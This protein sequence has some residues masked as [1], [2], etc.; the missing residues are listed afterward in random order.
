MKQ[1]QQKPSNRCKTQ[2]VA[3]CSTVRAYWYVSAVLGAP[4]YSP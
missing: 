2:L 4:L 1:Q 3:V